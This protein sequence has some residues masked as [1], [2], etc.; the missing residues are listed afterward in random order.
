MQREPIIYL[1]YTVF[2][3]GLTLAIIAVPLSA[4]SGGGKEGYDAFA[5]TCHQKLSRSLC[6]F[7]NLSSWWISDCTAPNGAY[8]ASASDRTGTRAVINGVTGYKMPVCARDVGLY[9]SMLFAALVY[10]LVR[11]IK[12]KSMYPGI[13]LVLAI[14]PLAID[15]SLQLFSEIDTPLFG[16][17]ILPFEYESSNAMRLVTGVL[18]GFAATFYALPILMNMFG[19]GEAAARHAE[20]KSAKPR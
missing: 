1:I 12:E 6:I 5:Y 17:S 3:L 4:F 15:G 7:N 13:I 14:A 2:F 19:D 9:V 11:D 16:H 18:A 10:P 8:V 20:K